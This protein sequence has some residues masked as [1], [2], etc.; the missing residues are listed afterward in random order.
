[1]GWGTWSLSKSPVGWRF[2]QTTAALKLEV[3]APSSF[4]FHVPGGMLGSRDKLRAAQLAPAGNHTDVAV[5]GEKFRQILFSVSPE[6][7]RTASRSS[8]MSLFI[9]SWELLVQGVGAWVLRRC[10][11]A[12]SYTLTFYKEKEFGRSR[13]GSA[14]GFKAPTK[15][16]S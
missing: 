3:H 2:L 11:S 7:G 15:S 10:K 5:K 8:T 13:F 16:K 9:C 6:K 1:M 14:S 12:S 4:L